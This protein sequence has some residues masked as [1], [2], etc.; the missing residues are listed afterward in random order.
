M[1]LNIYFMFLL[2]ILLW[3][4]GAKQETLSIATGGPAG[5]YY[6]IGGGMASIWS[7]ELDAVNV[8]AEVTGGSVILSLIHISEPTRPY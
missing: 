7:A 1:N 2:Q 5:L 4:C 8:K 6:P 3:G